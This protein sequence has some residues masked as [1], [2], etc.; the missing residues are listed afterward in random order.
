MIV[1]LDHVVIVA[2]DLDAAE[3]AYRVL[4]NREPIGRRDAA[5]AGS[6]HFQ[7][8]N[9]AV[10]LMAP[11]G[12]G[13]AGDRVR[14]ALQ[15]QGE[16]LASLAFRVED[17]DKFHRRIDRLG[18]AP[19]PIATMEAGGLT[20]RRTRATE[21]TFGIRHFF[22]ERQGEPPASPETGSGAVSGLDHVVVSTPNADRAASLYGARLKLDMALDRTN[23]NWGMRLMF[24]RCGDLIVEIANPLK[25]PT[26]DR[27]DSF[28][29]LTYRT[30]DIQAAHARLS[31][32]GLKVTAPHQGRK[33]GTRVFSV[34]DQ[35]C[36]VPTLLLGTE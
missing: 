36:G 20:W 18:L 10:E 5:G 14:A 35:T 28:Y 16:G 1:G 25:E 7:L 22:I 11:T 6:V 33:P 26:S 31:D 23:P 8:A 19:E 30:D 21:N 15:A 12:E 3:A 13:P 24:F 34:K 2:N 29:G 17:L 27:P 9:M 4:L 32:A